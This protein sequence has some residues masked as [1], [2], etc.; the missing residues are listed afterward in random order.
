MGGFGHSQEGQLFAPLVESSV[1]PLLRRRI[2]G[3]LDPIDIGR[4]LG[5]QVLNQAAEPRVYRGGTVQAVK[6]ASVD[7]KGVVTVVQLEVL[8]LVIDHLVAA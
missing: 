1:D 5:A 8:L 2:C 3:I 7:Q 4:L 6:L